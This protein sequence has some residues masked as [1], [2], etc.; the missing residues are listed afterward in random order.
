MSDHPCSRRDLPYQWEIQEKGP[1][2]ILDRRMVKWGN[3]ALGQV[4]VNQKEL[5]ADTP[6]LPRCCP[7]Q[8]RGRGSCQGLH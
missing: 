7:Q 1:E 2:N 4:L 5:E 3:K 8:L 6:P